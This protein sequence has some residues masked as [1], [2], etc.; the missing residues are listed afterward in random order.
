[1]DISNQSYWPGTGSD[2]IERDADFEQKRKS[3]I[4]RK[5]KS[6]DIKG[7]VRIIPGQGRMTGLRWRWCCYNVDTIVHHFLG[8]ISRISYFSKPRSG[9][10]SII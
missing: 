4:N 5:K 10:R 2:N 1:M 3:K 8:G 7:E 6:L 9:I